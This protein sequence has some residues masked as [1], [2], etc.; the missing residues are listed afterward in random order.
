MRYNDQLVLTGAIDDVGAPIRAN[1][2]KSYRLGIEVD[3]KIRISEYLSTLPNISFS[4]NKNIDF[5]RPLNGELVDLGN[6]N[7]SFSPDLIIGNALVYEPLKNMKVALLSKFVDQQ[8]M[9]NFDAESSKLDSYFVNDF[10]LNYQIDTNSIFKS[11]TLTALVNNIYNVKYVS[12]GYFYTYDDTWS[13][14]GEIVTI[15]GAGYYPQATTNFLM[16]ATFKF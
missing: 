2:G 1:S 11:I 6:T 7:I 4:S 14:P 13:T 15:E 9:S 5:T 3:A 12:N 8:Y 10:N 16:G